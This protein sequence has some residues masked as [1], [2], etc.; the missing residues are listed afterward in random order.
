MRITTSFLAIILSAGMLRAQQ[1]FTKMFQSPP[2]YSFNLIELPGHN[3]LA[4]LAG[5][6]LMDNEGY[7]EHSSYYYYSGETYGT[8]TLRAAGSNEFY[9]T[10]VTAYPPPTPACDQ[11]V[12]GKMDSLGSVSVMRRYKLASDSCNHAPGGL[13]VLENM[14]AISWGRDQDFFALR[15]HSDLG[16]RWTK[17]IYRSGGFRFI[18]ELPS[19]DLL[20][21][22]NMDTAGVVVARMN[23]DGNFLW[24][25]SYIRPRGIVHDV[26]LEPDGSFVVVGFTD[27]ME[28]TGL[29]GPPPP[30]SFQPKLFMMKLDSD[31]GC[32]GAVAGRALRTSGTL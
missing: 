12:I 17:R 19:G 2:S 26:L 9:F 5:T 25:K 27:S 11:P 23:A 13:E 8:Q 10:T 22:I 1:T 20:A 24:A 15:T 28:T 7:I 29:I 21:G 4:G 30:P 32:S 31:G 14:G 6:H 18:K 16:V 3:I